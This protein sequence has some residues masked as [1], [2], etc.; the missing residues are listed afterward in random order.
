MRILHAIPS[1]NPASGGPIEGVTQL[2]GFARRS[3]HSVEIASLDSPDDPWVKAFANV[4]Y[5]LGPGIGDFALAR[6][7]SLGCERTLKVR[8][9][10]RKWNLAV[11]QFR[12]AARIEILAYP[13]VVFTHGMLDPWFRKTYPWKH[14]KKWFYWP[15]GDYRVLA[16]A[17]AVFFTCAEECTLARRSFWLYRAKEVIVNYG[18]ASPPDDS[19]SQGNL[20]R[21]MLST[22][23]GK[24]DRI[25]L[26]RL[27][28]KKAATL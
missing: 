19:A 25:H 12:C 3:G 22:S 10:R 2:A 6:D 1:I 7:L 23:G 21:R 16:D 20:P 28:L 14:V 9:R 4:V 11:S 24:A 13:Y 18:T 8:H 27:H 17:A 15:W 26:G 5:P